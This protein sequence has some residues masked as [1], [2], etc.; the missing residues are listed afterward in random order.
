MAYDYLST[1][2]SWR[3]QPE[4]DAEIAEELEAIAG[5][6]EGIRER[7]LV[8]LSFGTAGLRGIIGAGT[9]RMNIY[10][11]RKTTQALCQ[12]I[13]ESGQAKRGVVIA[14]DSRRYSARFALEAALVLCGNGI[15]VSLFD[16]LRP[17]PVLSFAI[18]H[19]HAIAGIV[20]TASHNPAV[21]NGYKVYWEDGAQMP[22]SEADAVMN[23]MEGLSD[24]DAAKIM[25]EVDA[26]QQGLLRYINKDVDDPY[27]EKVKSLTLQPDLVARCAKDL[28]IIY[29]PVYGSGN[30]PVRR[31]LGELGYQVRVVE[32]QAE[33]NSAFPGM[34]APNPQNIEVFDKAIAIAGQEGADLL[35]ATDPDCD[36]LGV[37][38]YADGEYKTMSGNQIGCFLLYYICARLQ[39]TGKLPANGMVVK[40]IVSTEMARAIAEYYGAELVEVLTGFKFIA[41]QIKLHDETGE[42][43]F[44]FGFEESFGYLSGTFVRDKDAVIAAMLMS[45][46]AT[47]YKEQGLTIH[48]AMEEMYQR[49]GYY[50]EETIDTALDGVAGL[51]QV[52]VVMANVRSNSPTSLGDAQVLAVRDYNAGTRQVTDF[53]KQMKVSEDAS[54]MALPQTNAVYYELERGGWVCVRP[55][56]TEPKI[57]NY[58][59]VR[60]ETEAQARQAM[61]AL[62][63]DYAVWMAAMKPGQ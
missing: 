7:F 47:Y 5:D 23:I 44:L 14:Y 50:V 3:A 35:L 57:K 22:P 49:F 1:Y 6:D 58:L 39:A 16:S 55:S 59:A 19:L 20:I 37:T 11:V 62:R 56:G 29:T 25:T 30:I 12:V 38:Y 34:K 46:A 48:S 13:H 60:A 40:T 4:L 26:L 10:M 45:E 17:V 53:G 51:A 41:E 8:P 54:C 31:V 33:P 27:S 43:S 28:R 63:S 24:F 32:E 61:D 9:G 15:P 36:R 42:K 21:Y 52:P 2:N 18:R